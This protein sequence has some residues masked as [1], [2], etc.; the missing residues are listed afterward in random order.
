MRKFVLVALALVSLPALAAES[1]QAVASPMHGNGHNISFDGR[2]FIARR[3]SDGD[4]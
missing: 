4:E 1:T 3:G 2:L